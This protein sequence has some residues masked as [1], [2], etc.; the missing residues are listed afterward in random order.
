M[1]G[2][3]MSAAQARRVALSAQG[4]GRARPLATPDR[5][6]LR[7]MLGQIHLIQIDS[8]NVLMRAHYLP[9]WS[10]L[11]AYSRAA[12]DGMAY[13]DRELFEYWG[14]EAALLPVRLH[15]LMRWRMHRALEKLETWGRMARLAQEKPGLVEHVLDI[16]RSKGP[17]TAGEIAQEEKRSKDHWGWNWS[18]EK[19]AL[20][21]LFYTGQVTA[22]DRRNFERVYDVTERVLPRAVLDLATPDEH[23]A[24]REL[25]LLAAGALGVATVSDL[26]DYFR[27]RAPMA[28]PRV[29]ELVEDGRLREVDVEG[30]RHPAYMLPGTHVPRRVDARALLVPFD[31]LIFERDRTHRLFGFHYRIEIYVPAD[32]RKHGYYVLPFLLG[33]RLV[34]RVDLKSDR[35]AG[36]L[37]VQSAWSEPDAPADA[38]DALVA[39]LRALCAW[40]GLDEV[41]A[42]G[43]GTL[44]LPVQRQR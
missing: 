27:L 11:G 1:R 38:A 8:V 39:E 35:Q 23:E 30:W 7:R 36:L 14:H 20:E 10:R 28:R 29:A 2:M 17:V 6:H 12:L 19:T 9:G 25:L 3:S 15:P 31:P 18:D 42:T 16:V 34:A 32:K 37:R 40:L 43:R 41:V 5:R 4:F 44:A 22:A 24:H 21:F 33:D 13:R 26:A